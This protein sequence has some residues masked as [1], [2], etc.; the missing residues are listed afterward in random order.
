[1]VGQD[2]VRAL[3]NDKAC[4]GHFPRGQRVQFVYKH[5]GIDDHP[6]ADNADLVRIKDAG[7][8][9]MEAENFLADHHRVPGVVAALVP[10]HDVG[11]GRQ[12]VGYLPLSLV[13]PL[14]SDQ[15]HRRHVP[16]TP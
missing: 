13:A 11:L 9:Q 10:H 14:G 8:D 3:G 4:R 7:R 15:N 12:V 1:V 5:R 6:V 16:L 2:H